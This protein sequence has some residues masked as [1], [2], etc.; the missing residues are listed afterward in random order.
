[1]DDH[2][3]P[4]RCEAPR[5]VLG[6]GQVPD[7]EQPF[8]RPVL[9]PDPER[10]DDDGVAEVAGDHAGR[11]LLDV[12]DDLREPE[13]EHVADPGLGSGIHEPRAALL[14]AVAGRERQE[15]ELRPEEPR[16]AAR[17]PG[18]P[19]QGR[20]RGAVSHALT[21][22]GA[23]A[24]AVAVRRR[25]RRRADWRRRRL[26]LLLMSPWIVG[27]SVFFGYPPVM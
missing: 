15:P 22:A 26:V 18:R 13:V 16:Q 10:A 1:R 23:S 25:A 21:T 6:A 14:P 4:A 19:G 3:D 7:H 17:R 12:P 11:A 24:P 27:F 8:P 2:R 5:P 9:E 20:R